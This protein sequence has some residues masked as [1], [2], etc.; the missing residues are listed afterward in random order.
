[1]LF[2]IPAII[3]QSIVHLQYRVTVL[4]EIFFAIKWHV[5]VQYCVSDLNEIFFSSRNRHSLYSEL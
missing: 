5:Q 2:V 1:M 3:F 4:N